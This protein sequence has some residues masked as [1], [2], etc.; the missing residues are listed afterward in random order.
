MPKRAKQLARI[1]RVRG[2]QHG[3]AAAA[4]AR[5]LREVESIETSLH[6]LA[7]LRDGARPEGG[8]V[9][10]AMLAGIGELGAR[11]DDARVAMNSAADRARD[12]LA[13]KESVRLTARID[14][15]AVTRLTERATRAE[16]RLAERKRAAPRRPTTSFLEED[17]SWN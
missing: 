14:E 17:P 15:E 10:G 6:R 11:L 8:I 12:R 9:P 16:E 3:L 13:A 1:A 7:V 2:I 4:A 5:A